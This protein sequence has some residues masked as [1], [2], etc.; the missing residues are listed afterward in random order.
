MIVVVLVNS[1]RALD[2][3]YIMDASLPPISLE[4]DT[5]HAAT[6]Q[7]ISFATPD[8]VAS[9]DEFP[10]LAEKKPASGDAHNVEQ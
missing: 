1:H 2:E 9:T 5:N 3:A 6:P 10:E 7:R 4:V 8:S